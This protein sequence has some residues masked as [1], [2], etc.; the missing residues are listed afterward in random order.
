M[1]IRS[2]RNRGFTLIELLVVIAI[3]AILAAILFPVF[4]QA[5]TA[6]K[7][8]TS[9]SNTKQ[10]ATAHLIYQGDN[11][12]N[13][14]LAYPFNEFGTMLMGPAHPE[15]KY[16][17]A[18]V[19]ADAKVWDKAPLEYI[20][21]STTAWNNS[22][23]PYMKSIELMDTP[24]SVPYSDNFYQALTSRPLASLPKTHMTM[25]G[26]LNGYSGTAV[27]APSSVPLL[28]FGNGKESYNGR[29]FTNPYMRCN[30]VGTASNP[31]PPCRFNPGG[32]PQAGLTYSINTR[33]DTY[34]FSYEESN[35]TTW[36]HGEGTIFAMTDSS[37]KFVK[38]PQKGF[39]RG[40]R[41][42]PGYEYRDVVDTT[43]IP[44]GYVYDPAR[45]V[46]GSS[47]QPYLSFYRPDSTGAYDLGNTS[48]RAQ[49]NN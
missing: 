14:A 15:L 4:A 45:C 30:I 41:A 17:N 6:A 11:E 23:Q 28:A 31:A 48:M 10:T 12:D 42:H 27:A 18:L 20:Q 46:A 29:M 5:K 38:T 21:Y 2:C 1:I 43:K 32:V 33:A 39:N 22:I 35:D 24:M 7:K 9:V 16:F 25:N 13:F 19:P 44:G 3:I 37:A 36:T 49:C 47:G 26:L 40:S 34:E 8:T